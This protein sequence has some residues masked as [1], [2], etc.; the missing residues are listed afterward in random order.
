MSERRRA[1]A[2]VGAVLSV[3]LL[4][5]GALSGCAHVDAPDQ[6]PTLD[7]LERAYA[8]LRAGGP[9]ERARRAL[10]RAAASFEDLALPGTSLEEAL[11]SDPH[12]PYRGRPWERTLSLVLL[13]ALDA[14]RG[15]CDLAVPSLKSAA[16]LDLRA[17]KGEASDAPVIYALLLRCLREVGAPGADLE[18][19]RDELRRSLAL[20][21]SD[22]KLAGL[23][24][25]ELERRAL[26]P[27]LLLALDGEA[28]T[29]E[30]AGQYGE[31]ALLRVDATEATRA[32]VARAR[33]AKDAIVLRLGKKGPQTGP[34]DAEG[35]SLWSSARQAGTIGGRPF[36]E[37][38]RER[39]AMKGQAMREGERLAHDGLK[40]ARAP[41]A[42]LG[43]AATAAAG[44]GLFAA[45]AVVDARADTRTVSG[46][47]G[48]VILLEG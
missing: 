46:L 21:G 15:R 28:P 29:L 23:D 11:A 25:A 19:T 16:L 24:A 41:G 3:S 33:P 9:H 38:L 40:R 27:T 26:A 42:L 18:R 39:A 35:I 5:G 2:T 14:E 36:D 45:G 47:F 6:D 30:A 17:E 44:V 10:E 12:K 20:A 4:T 43:A 22:A 1:G 37:V 13:A 7:Q 31:S 48:R 8:T 34:P 32:Q